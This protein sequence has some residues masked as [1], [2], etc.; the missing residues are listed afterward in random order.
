MR[1]LRGLKSSRPSLPVTLYRG[2]KSVGLVV[3]LLLLFQGLSFAATSN[4]KITFGA[5][6][7]TAAEWP[8]YA[9]VDKGFMKEAG[10]DVD[11]VHTGSAEA[12]VQQLVAGA[13]QFNSVLIEAFM[14]GVNQGVRAKIIGGSVLAFPFSVIAQP[15]IKSWTDLKGKKISVSGIKNPTYVFV[16]RILAQYG[17]TAKGWEPIVAGSTANRYAALKSGA[18]AAAVLTQPFDFRALEEG[19]VKLADLSEID[20]NY[21]FRGI[22]TTDR[23]IRDNPDTVR[24]FVGTYARALN[25]LRDVKNKNEAMQILR[26]Y[27]DA[28][29][30]DVEATYDLYMALDAFSPSAALPER[31]LYGVM[32]LIIETGDMPKRNPIEIYFDGRFL[33]GR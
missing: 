32:D 1:V 17:M 7:P 4:T 28:T 8:I 18:V 9:A 16:N 23:M 11:I 13:T 31:Y 12:S 30:A 10:L 24:R 19:Y 20:P 27:I 2:L 26:K 14:R 15:N 6:S 3:G 21:G 29:P 25:W 5:V 33:T 22:A